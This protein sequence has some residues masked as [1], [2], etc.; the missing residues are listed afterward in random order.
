MDVQKLS[1][2]AAYC[3]EERKTGMLRSIESNIRS[4]VSFKNTTERFVDVYWINFRGE[5]VHYTNL[6]PGQSFMVREKKLFTTR[7]TWFLKILLINL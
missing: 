1:S 7:S 6:G 5:N 2:A 3:N 4:F